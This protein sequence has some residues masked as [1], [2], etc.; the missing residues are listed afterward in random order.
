MNREPFAVTGRGALDLGGGSPI[1]PGGS[2]TT[3]GSDEDF[4]KLLLLIAARAREPSDGRSL[5]Q[6]VCS[7][8]RQFFQVS[9]TYFSRL[10]SENELVGEQADGKMAQRFIGLRL[11]PG[12][13]AVTAEAVRQR[14]TIFVNQVHSPLFPA[15]AQ[16]E[17][18]S[19]MAAPL[20]VFNE[21][22]GAMT[23]LQRHAA[24][25]QIVTG[26]LYVD[27][28][29]EDLHQHFNTVRAPLNTLSEKELCPGQAALDKINAGLR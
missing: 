8:A 28:E 14:R 5:I 29:P 25:G 19:L 23:F 15:A 11:R 26:L 2:G 24:K 3:P 22:I 7:A 27:R 9:G 21:V 4:Q 17:A 12:E 16:Y 20:V 10:Q 18:R 13:S 1:I 6:L